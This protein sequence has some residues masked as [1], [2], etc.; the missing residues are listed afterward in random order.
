MINHFRRPKLRYHYVKLYR[1]EIQKQLMM[2]GR[3]PQLDLSKTGIEAAAADI[4]KKISLRTDLETDK[5][6]SFHARK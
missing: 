4:L 6:L 1:D 5:V 2:N 3:N